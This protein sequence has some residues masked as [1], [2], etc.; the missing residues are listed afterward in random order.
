MYIKKWKMNFY[1]M[2]K[3]KEKIRKFKNFGNNNIIKKNIKICQIKKSHKI[4]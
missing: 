1:K 3:K 4:K 2:D